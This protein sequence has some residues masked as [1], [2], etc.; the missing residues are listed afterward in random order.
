MTNIFHIHGEIFLV[1]LLPPPRKFLENCRYYPP[2]KILGKLSL[3]PPPREN[4]PVINFWK[5]EKGV[6]EH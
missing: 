1:S 2:S 6:D 3:L 5:Y 4:F